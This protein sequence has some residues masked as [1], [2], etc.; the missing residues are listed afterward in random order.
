MII[1]QLLTSLKQVVAVQRAYFSECGEEITARNLQLT[2]T[3]NQL[4]CLIYL[5]YWTITLLFFKDQLISPWYSLV[6][7]LM[8]GFSVVNQRLL[9]KQ[10]FCKTRVRSLLFAEYGLLMI[11]ILIMSVFPH[12]DMP[13]VYY[14]LFLLVAPVLLILPVYQHLLMSFGSLAV[15]FVLVLTCKSPACQAHDLF[16]ATTAVLLS[17]VVILLMAQYRVQS[18]FLKNKYYQLS[19]KDALTGTLNKSAGESAVQKYLEAMSSREHCALLFMDIDH[20]KQINDT[21]GHLAGDELLS[22]VGRVLTT[23]CRPSDVICRFGGDEFLVLLK[24]VSFSSDAFEKAQALSRAIS[25]IPSPTSD[26][27]T[28]SIGICFSGD[29]RP[30]F[31][32]LLSRADAALYQVKS[33]GKKGCAMDDGHS[34]FVWEKRM[35]Q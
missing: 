8:F 35:M 12:P 34:S 19:R 29:Q 28:C 2:A 3:M 11:Y 5:S 10:V 9:K 20:F 4:F 6:L 24:N 33:S 30:S 21:C 7:P 14:P 25:D 22:Q 15:F 32:E 17:M 27:L 23:H 31:E 18:D 13:A 26:L 1:N 16:E